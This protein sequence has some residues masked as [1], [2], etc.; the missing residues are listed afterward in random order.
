MCMLGMIPSSWSSNPYPPSSCTPCDPILLRK[1]SKKK[2]K[3]SVP[4]RP[5]FRSGRTSGISHFNGC[6]QIKRVSGHRER[7]GQPCLLKHHSLGFR[8]LVSCHR[9]SWTLR[10]IFIMAIRDLHSAEVKP[11]FRRKWINVTSCKSFRS[12]PQHS[13]FKRLH[14]LANTP[15]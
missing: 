2:E 11:S 8:F 7:N 15:A 12:S 1:K 6:S 5:G 14:T 4:G 3:P 10:I 9:S 13:A